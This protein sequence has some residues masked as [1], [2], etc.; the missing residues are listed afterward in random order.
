MHKL[1][2]VNLAS[3]CVTLHVH[4]AG[5]ACI[6]GSHFMVSTQNVLG[7]GLLQALQCVS[8]RS[9]PTQVGCGP[10]SEFPPSS[11]ALTAWPPII[12]CPGA[13]VACRKHS[14]AAVCISRCCC[15]SFRVIRPQTLS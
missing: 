2:L 10:A 1:Q 8:V 11:R 12:I 5:L 4:H 15:P 9:G 6:V 14:D 3:R 13:A 7:H